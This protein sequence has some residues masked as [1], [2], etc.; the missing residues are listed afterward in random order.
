MAYTFLQAVNDV[1]KRAGAIKGDAQEFTSFTSSARQID[2]DAAIF[3]WNDMLHDL[4]K[5]KL[6]STGIGEGSITLVTGQREYDLP[7]DFEILAADRMKDETNGYYLMPF[8]NG[9]VGMWDEQEVP[10]DWTGNPNY[11]VI[12]PTT[13]KFRLDTTPQAAENGRVYKFL[14]RKRIALSAITDTFPFSDTVVDAAAIA[15]AEM[16]K[17]YRKKEFDPQIMREGRSMAM[18]YLTQDSERNTYG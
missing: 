5:S 8:V 9:F 1:L 15:V 18:R 4:Y 12:N 7:S 11:Y 17:R 2:L 10:S 14:Y 6:F 16:W 13:N 3:C